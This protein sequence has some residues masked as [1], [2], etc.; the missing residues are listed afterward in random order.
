[1]CAAQLQLFGGGIQT[2]NGWLHWCVEMVHVA[3][4][5]RKE[6]V[7]S[8]T[9]RI[10]SEL[11]QSWSD[12]RR[13]SGSSTFFPKMGST[14]ISFLRTVLILVASGKRLW[15]HWSSTSEEWPETLPSR[16][17]NSK[18]LLVQVEAILNSRPIIPV[19]SDPN[20]LTYLTPGHF[21]VGDAL[22]VIPEA[23][24]KVT[25]AIHGANPPKLLEPVA[26]RVSSSL[27]AK[28]EVADEPPQIG[29]LVLVKDDNLPPLKWTLGLISPLSIRN[30][31]G[32][33]GAPLWGR[34]R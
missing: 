23:D 14:R 26:A 21:L 5:K 2:F 28:D 6:Y 34:L 24:T 4:W 16:S 3:V 11:I 19:F 32:L 17:W 22:T 27:S 30:L 29:H 12:C 1:M 8:T 33:I 10:S 7:L 13:R 20:E 9:E 18:T 25:L 15:S 31:T